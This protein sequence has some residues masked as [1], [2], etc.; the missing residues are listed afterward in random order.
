MTA[1]VL[2]LLALLGVPA[3]VAAGLL[4]WVSL[5]PV[6]FGAWYCTGKLGDAPIRMTFWTDRGAQKYLSG[7]AFM[8]RNDPY[9]TSMTGAIVFRPGVLARRTVVTLEAQTV[10]EE[11][12]R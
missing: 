4:V 1:A 11:M 6:L 2:I 9:R 5:W 12:L 10:E 8:S 3:L 7:T